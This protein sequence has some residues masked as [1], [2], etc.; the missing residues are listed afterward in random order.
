MASISTERY[1]PLRQEEW[2]RQVA[3][4][5][6]ATFL[7]QRP[8][9]DYHSQRFTD[10]SLMFC[11]GSKLI[12]LLPAN[13]LEDKVC[14]H[15]G[16]TY[17]GFIL[18]RDAGV[19]DCLQLFELA[20]SY[21][22]E[23][24]F[25]RFYYKALPS[26]YHQ[27]PSQDDLYC[28][29]RYHARRVACNIS[30]CIDSGCRNAFNR[31]RRTALRKAKENGVEVEETSDYAPFWKILSENL[32]GKYHTLP[33]HS[34][35]EIE[36]LAGRFPENIKLYTASHNGEPLAG[37]VLFLTDTVAHTQYLSTT[38]AG[39]TV[40]ALDAVLQFAME[41]YLPQRRYFDF[42]ISTE[43][44]GWFLNSGL[45]SQKE[46]FGGTGVVYNHYLI[47]L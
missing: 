12:A 5:R 30:T 41:K 23:L 34:L 24:G 27:Q 7:F 14:S 21:Y 37:A 17:G 16:L 33:V 44:D 28:L 26:I 40:G 35:Q 46:G 11:K 10:C 18:G 22:S 32:S 42:G 31:F 36:M 45:I 2:D 20:L 9:M 47:D 4:S 6:N 3:L 13:C 29:F 38:P 1:T 8:F 39:K 19:E 15:Q 25:K 43:Q